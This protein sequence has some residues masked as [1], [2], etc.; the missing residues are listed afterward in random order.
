MLTKRSFV[1][2]K[3]GWLLSQTLSYRERDPI[4]LRSASFAEASPALSADPPHSLCSGKG[5][6]R[7]RV[8]KKIGFFLLRHGVTM[9]LSRSGGMPPNAGENPGFRPWKHIVNRGNCVFRSAQ[10]LS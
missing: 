3:D 2:A 6:A 4:P 10:A 9:P 7:L 1:T 5:G 8:P